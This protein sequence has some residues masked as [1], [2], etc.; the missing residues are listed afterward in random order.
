MGQTADLVGV[1]TDE[2]D[3]TSSQHLKADQF[4]DECGGCRIERSGRLV[5]QDHARLIGQRARETQ[6]QSFTRRQLGDRPIK[7]FCSD[8]ERGRQPNEALQF[9][10][11]NDV[12]AGGVGPPAGLGRNV[13]HLTPP[14]AGWNFGALGAFEKDVSTGWIEIGKRSQNARF[15]G[16]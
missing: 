14:L 3:G 4:F 13:A 11:A 6:P 15:A 1:M 16:A 10:L 8:A 5:E 9:R 7:R 12:L 2:D